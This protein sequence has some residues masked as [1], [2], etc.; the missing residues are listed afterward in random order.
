[1]AL[2]TAKLQIAVMIVTLIVLIGTGFYQFGR[3]EQHIVAIEKLEHQTQS[4][5][6]DLSDDVSEIAERVAR[7]EGYL[8]K[9]MVSNL[10]KTN[11]D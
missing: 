1:M 11:G 2:N 10:R 6:H 3:Q 8:E 5:I 9:Q 7:I 4:E